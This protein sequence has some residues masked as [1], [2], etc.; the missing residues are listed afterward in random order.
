M[1]GISFDIT[2]K[3]WDLSVV[4]SC[5]RFLFHDRWLKL[6]LIY[7]GLYNWIFCSLSENNLVLVSHFRLTFLL[8]VI[9]DLVGVAVLYFNA[10]IL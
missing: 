10:I 2:I 8:R 6:R 5:C 4:V 9:A 3:K 7:V 1:L